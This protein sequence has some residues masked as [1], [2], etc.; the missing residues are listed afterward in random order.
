VLH[1]EYAERKLTLIVEGLAGTV[2]Q[3]PLFDHSF[4]S[5]VHA[6]GADLSAPAAR[7]GPDA[8][9]TAQIATAHFP[10]GEGWQTITVTLTW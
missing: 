6:E 2:A 10:P 1:E 4:K 8:S 3:F 9:P 7:S 5:R